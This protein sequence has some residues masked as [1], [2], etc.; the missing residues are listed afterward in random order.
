ME[1]RKYAIQLE[2]Y[3][4]IVGGK[5]CF[6]CFSTR[7]ANCQSSE[8]D[9]NIMRKAETFHVSAC[10]LSLQNSYRGKSRATFLLRIKSVVV[11]IVWQTYTLHGFLISI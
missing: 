8:V 3:L 4:S 11:T 7:I 9:R 6:P 5:N 10:L 1:T 2:S